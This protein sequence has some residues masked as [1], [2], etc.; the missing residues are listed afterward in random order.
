MWVFLVSV[1]V[2]YLVGVLVVTVATALS[3]WP[4]PT[5]GPRASPSFIV[6][7]AANELPFIV[8]YWLMA[9]TALA[10]AQGDIDSPLGWVALAIAVCTLVGSTVVIGRAA[11]AGAVLDEALTIGLGDNWRAVAERPGTRRQGPLHGIWPA[12]IAPVRIPAR[13]VRRE[14]DI[15]YGPAGRANR[16]DVYRHR[17]RPTGCPVLIYFH[18]GGFVIG[19][20]S[21][22]A[23]DLFNRLASHG[24]LCISANYRLRQAGAFPHNV[25]DAKRVIAWLRAHAEDYGADPG[26][27]V[28]CGGSA[29]AYLAAMCALTADDPALQPGFEQAD[30]SVSAAVGLYGFYGSA[31]SSERRP[32]DPGAYVRADAPPFF[33]IPAANDPMV[34]ADHAKEFA[35][36]LRATSMSP[37]LYAEL[38]GGQHNFDR[39]SSIRFFAVIDAVEAFAT[40]IRSPS[41]P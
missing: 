5:Q 12:L 24:W 1:A 14:R 7:S 30:T 4:R 17:S 40:W 35:E 2:G 41:T 26:T 36:K 33:V 13:S 6:E 9:D 19:N 25:I 10:A 11:R 20:K 39:F 37:V 8:V 21:R 15:T 31:G 38:P 28:M 29:G 34:A 22:E 16:L 32:S 18:P 27:I 3:L 23:R